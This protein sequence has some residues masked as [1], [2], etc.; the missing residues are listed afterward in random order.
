MPEKKRA[1]IYVNADCCPGLMEQLAEKLKAKIGIE[2]NAGLV[3]Q[4]LRRWMNQLQRPPKRGS[5]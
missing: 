3:Y 4:A 5:A 1:G 2:F